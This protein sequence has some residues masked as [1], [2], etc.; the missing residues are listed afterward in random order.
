[1]LN[2]SLEFLIDVF[3]KIYPPKHSRIP[4]DIFCVNEIYCQ[5]PGRKKQAVKA[6]VAIIDKVYALKQ[7][8]S[9]LARIFFMFYIISLHVKNFKV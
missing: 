7:S 4:K 8:S 9:M 2:K 5:F 3:N 1:M 6:R